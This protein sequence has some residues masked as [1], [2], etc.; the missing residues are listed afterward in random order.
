MERAPVFIIG[1]P[2]SGTTVFLDV[3]AAHDGLAWVS[4]QLDRRPDQPA[5]ALLNRLYQLPAAGSVLY[6]NRERSSVL[7]EASEPWEFFGYHLDRFKPRTQAPYNEEPRNPLPEDMS[8]SEVEAIR[9]A[10]S[11]VMRRQ[12]RNLFVSKYTDYPRMQYLSKAFPDARFVH[13]IRD[14][15]AVALSYSDKMNSGSFGTW[16]ERDVWVKAISE[17]DRNRWEDTE[18]SPLTLGLLLWKYFVQEIRTEAPEVGDRYIEVRYSDLVKNRHAMLTDVLDF[19]G[20]DWTPRF[21]ADVARM[22]LYDMNRKWR[23]KL[24]DHDKDV[25]NSLVVEPELRALL[26]D[27]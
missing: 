21:A 23:E 16:D 25:L 9:A 1:C 14:G 7:P 2:R 5:R 13:I 12:N 6:R 18:Q 15:R 11:D 22:D 17:A 4:D 26:D 8:D 3:L 24:P 20:L 19:A 27:D 10:V